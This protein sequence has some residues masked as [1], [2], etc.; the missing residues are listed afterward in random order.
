MAVALLPV[1]RADAMAKTAP[2][3][4]GFHLCCDMRDVTEG[5]YQRYTAPN[6]YVVGQF[7]YCCPTASQKP[8]HLG[9]RGDTPTTWER[10]GTYYGRDVFR[11]KGSMSGSGGEFL[12]SNG[13]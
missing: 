4:I 10:A 7:Y 8:P 9:V 5:R 6:V 1:W 2:E 12:L 13:G 11:T 3:I